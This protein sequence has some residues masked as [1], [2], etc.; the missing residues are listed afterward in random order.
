MLNCGIHACPERCH[1]EKCGTVSY[2]QTFSCCLQN[3]QLSCQ[4]LILCFLCPALQCLEVTIKQCRCGLHRKELPC[5]KEFLCETKCKRSKDCGR[6]PCNRKVHEINLFLLIGSVT[7][8]LSKTLYCLCCSAVTPSVH[9]VKKFVDAPSDVVSI[10]VKQ[11]VIGVPVTL[12]Q[13]LLLSV[14]T[15][16]ELLWKYHVDVRGKLVH[17]AVQSYACRL[18][19]THFR[20]HDNLSFCIYTTSYNI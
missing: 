13:W 20:W 4:F 7:T 18:N 17:L 3:F 11:S 2:D 5:A 15:V 10:N 9:L 8:W 12:V 14:A 16:E 19:D 6:H 1:R